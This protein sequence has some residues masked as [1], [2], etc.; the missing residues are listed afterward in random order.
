VGDFVW[1]PTA[2]RVESANITRLA[3]SLGV[4]RYD[5]LHRISIDDPERFWPA[6]L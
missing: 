1:T 3:R 6:V 5:D 2:E 4:E